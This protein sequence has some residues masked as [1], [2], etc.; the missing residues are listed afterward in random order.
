MT[1]RVEAL[2]ALV[3]SSNRVLPTLRT[4]SVIVAS[5]RLAAWW[6]QP[7]A[8]VMSDEWM[9]EYGWRSRDLENTSY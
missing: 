9:Q 6:R 8:L 1:V 7:A 3:G 4:L 2:D 5:R